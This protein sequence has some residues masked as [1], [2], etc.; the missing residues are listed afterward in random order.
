M[1]S[2]NKLKQ[3]EEEGYLLLSGL[4]PKETVIKAEAAMWHLM[5]ME[6]DNPD[7]WE[8]FQRPFLTGFYMDRLADG[9][10]L[11]L[12]GVNHPDVLACCTPDYLSILNQLAERY[13]SIPHC[14]SELPDGI[15]AMNQFPVSSEWKSPSPHLDGDFRD[16]RLDPGTFRATSITYLTDANSQQGTTVIWPE[17]PLRIRAFRKKNPDFSNHVRDLRA[18][19]PQL[20]LGEPMEVVAKQGDVLLFHHLLPHSGTINVGT[21][22]RF[23]IRY[24]CLCR[25]CHAWQKKGEWNIWMP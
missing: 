13:P 17:G 2:S 15:W 1:L 4:I 11:E 25:D 10:R 3:F 9:K 22:P 16:F 18:Q 6:P 12:Y 8:H 21:S 19:F 5:G 14:K 23:A 20:D 7:T 24:M